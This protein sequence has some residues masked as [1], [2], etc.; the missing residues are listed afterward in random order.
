MDKAL[1]TDRAPYCVV[2]G[3]MT[4]ST[5]GGLGLNDDS[6]T[7]TSSFILVRT[8]L[9]A[10]NNKLEVDISIFFFFYRS[11]HFAGNSVDCIERVVS[12]LM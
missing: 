3:K 9:F 8:F 5:V 6:I 10:F 4:C 11:S 7:S 1:W 12:N 2:G